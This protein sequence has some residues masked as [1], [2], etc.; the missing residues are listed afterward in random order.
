VPEHGKG[1]VGVDVG[2]PMAREVLRRGEDSEALRASNVGGAEPGRALRRVSER[3]SVDDG[4]LRV[5]VQIEDRIQKK[6]YAERPRLA[7]G[8]LRL[9]LEID[10]GSEGP[11][12]HGPRKPARAFDPHRRSPLVVRRHEEREPR[13]LLETVPEGRGRERIPFEEDDASDAAF[14][15][16]VDEAPEER[17]RLVQEDPVRTGI[18]ELPDLL[19]EAERRENLLGPWSFVRHRHGLRPRAAEREQEQESRSVP[20]HG[21]DTSLQFSA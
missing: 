20:L 2:S 14:A 13:L 5:G 8:D 3:A 18:D 16:G 21:N 4:V 9:E 12:R 6:V 7:G 1:D 17:V 19:L 11:H 10:L 15:G